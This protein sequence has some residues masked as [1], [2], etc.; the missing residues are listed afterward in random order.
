[1]YSNSS[2]I[3]FEQGNKSSN[4]VHNPVHCEQRYIRASVGSNSSLKDDWI[5]WLELII[6]PVIAWIIVA[7]MSTNDAV[8]VLQTQQLEDMRVN[9]IVYE[10]KDSL[11]R[12]DVGVE[13]I[14]EALD[15]HSKEGN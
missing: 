6:L 5:R 10:M 4:V 7:I 2:G 1:M 15:N 3:K 12:I 9:G 8:A 13:Y 11:T 14:K